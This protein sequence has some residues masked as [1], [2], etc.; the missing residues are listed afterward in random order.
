MFSTG[1]PNVERDRSETT[2]A[3]VGQNISLPCII[4]STDNLK[5]A[6]IEWRKKNTKLAL[7]SPIH[8]AYVFRPNI[9]IK[10]VNNNVFFGGYLHLPAVNEWDSGIYV[11]DTV[12]FPLGTIRREIELKIK[13]TV[14]QLH[15]TGFH[16]WRDIYS[17]FISTTF[18]NCCIRALFH[19]QSHTSVV[20]F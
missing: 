12:T 14:F 9:T 5:I 11:C 3:E 10:P 13:G 17:N 20:C 2:E 4:N 6:N 19:L 8:G 1:L 18:H 15:L 7:Y 16:A